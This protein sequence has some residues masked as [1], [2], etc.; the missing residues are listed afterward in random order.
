MQN[1]LAAGCNPSISMRGLI[2]CTS[3][4]CTCVRVDLVL[5]LRVHAC[6]LQLLEQFPAILADSSA[7]AIAKSSMET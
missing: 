6:A 3:P 1:V 5:R 7:Q 2:T 4:A